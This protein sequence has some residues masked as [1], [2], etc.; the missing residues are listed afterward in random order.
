MTD[1]QRIEIYPRQAFTNDLNLCQQA[2]HYL[3]LDITSALEADLYFLSA[4][5]LSLESIQEVLCDEVTHRAW[6]L[7]K[8]QV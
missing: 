5:Q 2:T 7:R 8:A 4:H 3:Q 6:S 1:L